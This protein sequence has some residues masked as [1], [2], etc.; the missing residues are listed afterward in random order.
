MMTDTVTT[1]NPANEQTLN[2]Y[3]LLSLQ[4]AQSEVDQ[5]HQAFLKWRSIFIVK[6][7]YESKP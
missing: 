3:N 6:T 2:T 7:N 4:Q 5:C 1:I